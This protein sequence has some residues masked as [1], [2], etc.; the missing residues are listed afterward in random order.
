MKTDRQI[1]LTPVIILIVLLI[2]LGALFYYAGKTADGLDQE[3]TTTTSVSEDIP[4]QAG[5]TSQTAYVSPLISLGAVNTVPISNQGVL[6]ERLGWKTFTN[7]AESYAVSYPPEW[8][9]L[10]GSTLASITDGS[11]SMSVQAFNLAP[12]TTPSL[13]A[14]ENGVSNGFESTTV[15]AYDSIEA[16]QGSNTN[17]FIVN[18]AVGYEISIPNSTTAADAAVLR[19]MLLTFTV[20]QAR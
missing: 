9:L 6:A 15:N 11:A 3:G 19:A 20:T 18:G 17:Y 7:T 2:A 14:T 8:Q 10:S 1:F 5:Q 16:I 12:N 13:F 4:G